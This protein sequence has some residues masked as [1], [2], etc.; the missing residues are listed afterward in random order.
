MR[1][2]DRGTGAGFPEP[3]TYKKRAG[4]ATSFTPFEPQVRALLEKTPTLPATVIAERVGWTGSITWFRDNI[5]RI[6]PD[7][8]PVD[9]VDTL[10]HRP[11]EQIQCDLTFPTGGLPDETGTRAEFPVL[12]MVA[13]HSCV[14]S[15]FCLPKERGKPGRLSGF[16][17]HVS[18]RSSGHA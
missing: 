17:G 10:T 16:S 6:R 8:Q 7:Y 15:T 9:P 14:L 3:P 1:E 11:G 2:K 5:R 18:V 12:V 4:K 13:S